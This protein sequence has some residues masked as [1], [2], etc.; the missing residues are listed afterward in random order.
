MCQWSRGMRECIEEVGRSCNV[1]TLHSRHAAQFVLIHEENYS[2]G[3]VQSEDVL[4]SIL[5]RLKNWCIWMQPIR[6]RRTTSGGGAQWAKR[7]RRRAALSADTPMHQQQ[8]QQQE[9]ENETA[10]SNCIQKMQSMTPRKEKGTRR[11]NK[12]QEFHFRLWSLT[13]QASRRRR[14]SRWSSLRNSLLDQFVVFLVGWRWCLMYDSADSL[15]RFTWPT[16][17]TEA[18]PRMSRVTD[19]IGGLE[20]SFPIII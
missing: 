10:K 18:R 12:F 5:Y 3:W 17:T 8:Q 15:I 20:I 14:C 6:L 11:R 9:E 13:V 2:G 4:G 16:T 1:K 7:R 19:R